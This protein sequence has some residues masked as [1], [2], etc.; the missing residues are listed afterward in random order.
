MWIKSTF[1]VKNCN[2]KWNLN[3]PNDFTGVLKQQIGFSSIFNNQES[4][5]GKKR[6]GHCLLKNK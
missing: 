2:L 3:F 6:N 1:R 5:N 4:P